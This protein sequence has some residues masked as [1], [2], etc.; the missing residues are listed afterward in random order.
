MSSNSDQSLTFFK[1]AE[2]RNKHTNQ[3]IRWDQSLTL[4]DK[5]ESR[6]WKGVPISAFR[7]GCD[8]NFFH[9]FIELSLIRFKIYGGNLKKYRQQDSPPPRIL[10]CSTNLD[11]LGPSP[12]KWSFSGHEHVKFSL[13]TYSE[14]TSLTNS[15]VDHS[16]S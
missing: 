8:L 1:K 16:L 5:T 10:P 6:N 14:W 4:S 13:L 3:G 12:S 2:S 11:I 15:L 9:V 7:F